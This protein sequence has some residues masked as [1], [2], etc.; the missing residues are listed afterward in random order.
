MFTYLANLECNLPNS[1]VVESAFHADKRQENVKATFFTV[2]GL[3]IKVVLVLPTI[4][5]LQD[6]ITALE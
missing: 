1:K 3:D 5:E 6:V 2:L 4:D